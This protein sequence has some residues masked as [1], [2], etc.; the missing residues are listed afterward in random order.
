MARF[1]IIGGAVPAPKDES[2]DGI[3]ITVRVEGFK[4][5]NGQARAL[6]GINTISAV[7]DDDRVEGHEYPLAASGVMLIAGA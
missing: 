4:R 5:K 7:L 3:D 2:A 6:A 1:K